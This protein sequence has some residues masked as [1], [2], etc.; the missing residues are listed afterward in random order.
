MFVLSLLLLFFIVV[1]VAAAVVVLFQ[2]Q[3]RYTHNSRLLFAVFF[4]A[5]FI[6]IFIYFFFISALN[7]LFSWV[8]FSIYGFRRVVFFRFFSVHDVMKSGCVLEC[9][10]TESRKQRKSAFKINQLMNIP[11]EPI[12]RY[13]VDWNETNEK[14]KQKR[15]NS[16]SYLP[17]A[18]GIR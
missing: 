16:T 18:Y 2:L 14:E 11:A 1:V 17:L 9:N 7:V 6:S 12:D 13:G 15:S 10:D 5:F 8:R 3:L 4:L